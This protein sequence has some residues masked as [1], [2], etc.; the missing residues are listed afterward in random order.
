M[1]EVLLYDKYVNKYDMAIVQRECRDN[2]VFQ[3][4]HSD[5]F[6]SYSASKQ[7]ITLIK[8]I[9]ALDIFGLPGNEA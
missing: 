5:Y 9:L 7:T 2:F 6:K 8:N 4:F 1:Y 3:K